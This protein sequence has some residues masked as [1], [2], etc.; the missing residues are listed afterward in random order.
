MLNKPSF[1]DAG[2]SKV[3]R[4]ILDCLSEEKRCESIKIRYKTINLYKLS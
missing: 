4:K 2:L 3:Y 1:L